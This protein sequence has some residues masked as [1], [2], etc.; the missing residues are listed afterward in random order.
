MDEGKRPG[1]LTALAIF[2]LIFA[3]E[4]L[5]GFLGLAG[6]Y[7][8]STATEVLDDARAYAQRLLEE[9]HVTDAMLAVLMIGGLVTSLLLLFSAIGYLKQKR[10][11]GR[12]LGNLYVLA[13]VGQTAAMMAVL[14]RELG[15]YFHLGVLI[16]LVY[17]LLTLFFVNVTFREDFIR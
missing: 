6:L 17:P 14:P 15:G 7:A 12:G 9:A 8:V 1:G 4:G 16:G 3:G 10:V 5:L 13:A 11:L 2:N